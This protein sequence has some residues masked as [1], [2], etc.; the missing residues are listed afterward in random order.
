MFRGFCGWLAGCAAATVVIVCLPIFFENSRAGLMH[1]VEQISMLLNPLLLVFT[2][3]CAMTALPAMLLIF[4]SIDLQA[5]SPVFYGIAGSLLGAL[6]ISL[7]VR[8]F[9]VLTI[10]VGPL[11]ALAGFVAGVIY[12]LVAGRRTLSERAVSG[13]SA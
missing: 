3:T 7:L 2:V 13:R 12:W 11:F 10:W 1:P 4:L 8:S 6:C 9:A 5:R